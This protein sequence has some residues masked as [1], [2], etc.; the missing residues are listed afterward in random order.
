MSNVYGQIIANGGGFQQGWDAQQQ[1]ENQLRAQA[2]ELQQKQREAQAIAA[3]GKYLQG[4]QQG[5]PQAP[6]PQGG[7]PPSM[8][9]PGGPPQQRMPPQPMGQPAPAPGGGG[10]PPP[11]LPGGGG[12]G[13]GGLP[14]APQ[15]QPQM[16][17][18]P[19][20]PAQPPIQPQAGPAGGGMDL[21]QLATRIKSSN[22]DIDDATL[23]IAVNNMSGLLSQ[24]GQAQLAAAA[25]YWTHED[26]VDQLQER[27]REANQRSED[28]KL[29]IAERQAA[30]SDAQQ[31][32]VLIANLVQQGQASRQ[33]TAIEAKK[34][35]TEEIQDK[36]DA[37]SQKAIEARGVT[38]Q[39]KASMQRATEA[40]KALIAQRQDIDGQIQEKRFE[41]SNGTGS[42]QEGQK[43]IQQLLAQRSQINNKIVA[44]WQGA[45]GL[46]L[47]LPSPAELLK[48]QDGGSQSGSAAP[49][50][51]GLGTGGGTQPSGAAPKYTVGQ[52][53]TGPDG[54]K[55]KITG[56]DLGGDPDVEPVGQ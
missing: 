15:P 18:P 6:G 1:R 52:I 13:G 45:Q 8:P 49:G 24:Q 36:I 39:Q 3:L 56:G 38:G 14:A 53:V 23:F 2:L 20:A 4:G 54:K 19:Q 11:A 51:P 34:S 21:S 7:P 17:P 31:T 16:Q 43:A 27:A 47:S 12:G 28:T 50:T 41:I 35:L 32:R 10:G 25:K 30:A 9:G 5:V 37:R 55:Y 33:A 40:Y 22:P 42:M 26:R 48:G 29:S 44:T 46:G